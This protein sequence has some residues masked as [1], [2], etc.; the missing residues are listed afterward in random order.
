MPHFGWPRGLQRHRQNTDRHHLHTLGTQGL[1]QVSPDAMGPAAGQ[2]RPQSRSCMS[3][4]I[5]PLQR[6]QQR[7]LQLALSGIDRLLC[8]FM[9]RQNI[10][11]HPAHTNSPQCRPQTCPSPTFELL[12]APALHH[13]PRHAFGQRF[14]PWPAPGH[15]RALWVCTTASVNPGHVPCQ[16]KDTPFEAASLAGKASRR[17]RCK[18]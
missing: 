8:L 18:G 17:S 6:R 2:T 15:G 11:G 12:C 1:L 7:R 5:H 16:T 4:G 3:G 9:C 14:Q 13:R 10:A